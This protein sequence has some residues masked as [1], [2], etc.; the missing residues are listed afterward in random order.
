MSETIS[1]LMARS[2]AM[3]KEEREATRCPE[4]KMYYR[5]H[6][7]SCSLVTVESLR[8]DLAASQK[9]EKRNRE[10]RYIQFRRMVEQLTLWQGK[11]HAIRHENNKLRRRLN[12]NALQPTIRER[13]IE[14]L[15]RLK[16][17][18]MGLEPEEAKRLYKI[19]IDSLVEDFAALK[20]AK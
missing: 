6:W 2:H 3:T 9:L 15:K 10:A 4:C 7:P 16:G 11:F 5:S 13:A 19:N 18:D 20:E 14:A 1:E 17:W 12:I 8:R